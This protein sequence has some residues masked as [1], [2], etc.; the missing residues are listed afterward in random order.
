MY[1][2]IFILFLFS[3][4]L[5]AQTFDAEITDTLQVEMLPDIFEKLAVIEENGGRIDIKENAPV[6]DLVRIHIQ[7]N[8]EQKTV[9]GYR[10][11]I[12]SGSSYDYTVERL[13]QMKTDFETEFPDIPVYLN[14]FD[15]DFKIRAG[16]FRSRLEC[17][18][19]LKR[20]RARYPACYPV[21]TD[22]PVQDL[23]KLS[24]SQTEETEEMEEDSSSGLN[25]MF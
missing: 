7:Q 4:S 23:K 9:P 21:K 12:F 8:R 22:I 3:G 2:F 11:Q 13:Q 6:N 1:K 16:N 18:P 19:V 25:T 14:Y 20:I 15:P 5:A 17:I 24:Q 10:I